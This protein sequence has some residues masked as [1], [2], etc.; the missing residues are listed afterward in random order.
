MEFI[1]ERFMI[2]LIYV[3]SASKEMTEEELLELLNQARDRNLIKNI[4]GMLLYGK[5]SFIQIL[6]GK[7]DDVNE[8]Y[9]SIQNDAR[10][11]GNIIIQK[12]TIEGRAFPDWTMGFKYL[13][14]SEIAETQG[15]SDFFLTEVDLKGVAQ[16]SQS[17]V[18]MLYSFKKNVSK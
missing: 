2:H 12:K 16:K 6:E 11:T 9:D 18:D 5:Q 1:V 15:Y 17:V 7:V 8:I 4:T 14:K 10:N 3:S 13:S